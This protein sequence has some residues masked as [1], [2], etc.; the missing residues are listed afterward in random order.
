MNPILLVVVFW[1]FHSNA[2]EKPMERK[3]SSAD[4]I[5]IITFSKDSSGFVSAE[6]CDGREYTTVSMPAK[7]MIDAITGRLAAYSSSG[8]IVKSCTSTQKDEFTCFLSRK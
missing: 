5:C 1:S 7:R 4:Q 6:S 8:L 2:I 3:P